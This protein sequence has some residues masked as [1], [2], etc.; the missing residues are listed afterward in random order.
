M[1]LGPFSSSLTGWDVFLDRRIKHPTTGAPVGPGRID[2]VFYAD[3]ADADDIKRSLV[4]HDGY[5]DDI[6]VT[7]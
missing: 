7:R 6:E 1:K 4:E 2:T 3:N 5:P